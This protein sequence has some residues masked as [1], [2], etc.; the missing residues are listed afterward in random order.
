[1][2][3]SGDAWFTLRL[4]DIANQRDIS[5]GSFTPTRSSTSVI[6]PKPVPWRDAYLALSPRRLVIG[7][8]SNFDGTAL[9]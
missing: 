9:G 5:I 4:F 6:K 8:R 1:V 7:F 2:F 3:V